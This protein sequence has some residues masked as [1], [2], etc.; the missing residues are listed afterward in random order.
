MK[1]N[2]GGKCGNRR[3]NLLQNMTPE[4]DSNFNGSAAELEN[5]A[6]QK[7][8]LYVQSRCF[9]FKPQNTILPLNCS[10]R[11]VFAWLVPICPKLLGVLTSLPGAPKIGWF[12]ML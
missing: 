6:A 5:S 12:K 9:E 7:T 4:L 1:C 10:S 2:S 3:K 8:A 11:F